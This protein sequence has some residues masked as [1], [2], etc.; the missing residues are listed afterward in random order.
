[1]GDWKLVATRDHDLL[2]HGIIMPSSAATQCNSS[3]TSSR[4]FV[5]AD[6]DQLNFSPSIGGR[7]S[8]FHVL[9]CCPVGVSIE[10][11][12]LT[13]TFNVIKFAS[14]S[15]LATSYRRWHS[16]LRDLQILASSLE[17]PFPTHQLFSFPH[18][19]VRSLLF[20]LPFLLSRF[21][22]HCDQLLVECP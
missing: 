16:R 21:G 15:R 3:L 10:I 12:I 13:K 11:S 4:M 6:H 1:M 7:S 19:H 5:S 17:L 18:D 22:S 2:S 9:N 20:V 14:S 8:Q